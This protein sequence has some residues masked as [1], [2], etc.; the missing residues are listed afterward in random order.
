VKLE[1]KFLSVVAL[2]GAICGNAFAVELKGT[3]N[4]RESSETAA[5]A[6]TKAINSA[7]RQILISVLSKYSDANALTE[8]VNNT[9]SN[10]LL[11]II[12]SS[13]VS[14]EQISNAALETNKDRF[15]K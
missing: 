5:E 10:D 1:F 4:V 6:K 3:V 9:S 13:S 12:S 8:L 7:R 2:A 14:N 15:R 11:N